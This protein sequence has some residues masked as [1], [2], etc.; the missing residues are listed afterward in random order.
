[1]EVREQVG[2]KVVIHI[3]VVV[4]VALLLWVRVEMVVMVG[5]LDQQLQ[6]MLLAVVEQDNREEMA[7]QEGRVIVS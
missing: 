6:D 1:V 3:V 4:V 7:E 2:R 5:R